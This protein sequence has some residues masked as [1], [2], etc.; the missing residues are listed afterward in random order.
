MPERDAIV[1]GAGPCGSTAATALVQKGYDVLLL[2][3]Q[4]FPRDKVCG[5]NITGEA[6]ELLFGIGMEEKIREA[7][8]YPISSF[9]LS[10]PKGY[11]IEAE[12]GDSGRSVASSYVVP[13]V[14]F[15]LLVQQHAIESGAEFQVAHVTGPV[16]ENGRVVG[17]QVRS[18]G[19]DQIIL[20]KVVIGADGVSSVIAQALKSDQ[21]EA[22]HRAVALRTY[23]DDIEE[24]PHRLEFY[25]PG[26]ILPGYAWKFHAG[27]GRVNLGLGMRLD[28]FRKSDRSLEELLEIFLD[29]PIIRKCLQG[30]SRPNQISVGQLN[31]GSQDIQRA[32]DGALLVGDAAG[33]VNPLSGGGIRNGLESALLA[34]D[35]IE[36]AL[37]NDDVSLKRLRRYDRAIRAAMWTN[38]RR[39]YLIQRNMLQFPGLV[40]LLVRFFGS[41]RGLTSLIIRKFQPK[42]GS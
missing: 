17:V 23:I 25:L 13:R 29:M 41:D 5:D 35:I 9:L 18:N 42:P 16:V 37:S 7:D 32:F 38:M 36:D 40:D 14:E 21:H 3:R 28:K 26:C 30:S 19:D 24:R 12:I 33:L 27:G 39:S 34:A 15:D 4:K 6:I 31:L 10:S 22:R 20:S 1:V 2:D 11:V 8:F